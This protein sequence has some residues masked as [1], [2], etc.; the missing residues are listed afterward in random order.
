MQVINYRGHEGIFIE[1]STLSGMGRTIGVDVYKCKKCGIFFTK[2]KSRTTPGYHIIHIRRW[3][4]EFH[5]YFWG[6]D[7]YDLTAPPAPGELWACS[8][9]DRTIQ[10]II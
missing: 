4:E 10:E 9:N 5:D 2:L 6:N 7:E 3:S 1:H 8:E